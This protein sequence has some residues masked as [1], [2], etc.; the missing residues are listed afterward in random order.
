MVFKKENLKKLVNRY[1]APHNRRWSDQVQESL[2]AE[3]EERK[4]VERQL[5]GEPKEEVCRNGRFIGDTI[6]V[7]SPFSDN[8]PILEMEIWKFDTGRRVIA[9]DKQGFLHFVE[10]SLN[11]NDSRGAVFTLMIS[12]ASKISAG[13]MYAKSQASN[14]VAQEDRREVHRRQLRYA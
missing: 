13:F 4:A 8:T 11:L 2:A 6:Q 3:R 7:F 9:I 10:P 5:F 1:N 14:P 12:G